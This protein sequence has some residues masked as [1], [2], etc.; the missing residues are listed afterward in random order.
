MEEVIGTNDDGTP[1]YGKLI[2]FEN[3]EKVYGIRVG[4]DEFGTP[5][6]AEQSWFDRVA[7]ADDDGNMKMYDVDM[8]TVVD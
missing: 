2:R 7:F 4:E 3:G 8:V 5:I 1:V 6:Y